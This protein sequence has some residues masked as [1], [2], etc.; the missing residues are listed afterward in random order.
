MQPCGKRLPLGTAAAEPDRTSCVV[1]VWVC[2]VAHFLDGQGSELRG[3]CGLARAKNRE[4]V[5]HEARRYHSSTIEVPGEEVTSLGTKLSLALTTLAGISGSWGE[6]RGKVGV[7]G[8]PEA[9]FA[10]KGGKVVG[11]GEDSEGGYSE[12]LSVIWI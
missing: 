8:C 7:M 1:L 9:T 6:D 5:T 4:R 2:L 10:N 3:T 11:S 12:R